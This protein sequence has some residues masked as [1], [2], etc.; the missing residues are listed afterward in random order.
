MYVNNKNK[1]KKKFFWRKT[2]QSE[3]MQKYIKFLKGP[4]TKVKPK[5]DKNQFKKLSKRTFFRKKKFQVSVKEIE[6]S[7]IME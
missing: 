3:K 5:L 4:T 2:L 6:N 1:S 7:M